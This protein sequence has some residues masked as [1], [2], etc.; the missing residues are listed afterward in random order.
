MKYAYIKKMHTILKW[1][2]ADFSPEK[3]L[4]NII[5]CRRVKNDAYV[6]IFETPTQKFNRYAT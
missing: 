3:S 1:F 2:N 4:K 6:L 5:K